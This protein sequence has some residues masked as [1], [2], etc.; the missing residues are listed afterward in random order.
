MMVWPSGSCVPT[1]GELGYPAIERVG[2]WT[3]FVPARTPAEIV[4][5]LNVAVR[6]AVRVSEVKAG[7]TNLSAEIGTMPRAEFAQLVKA[8]YDR[9]ATIVQASGFT[10]QD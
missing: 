8:E 1:I 2:W 3:V 9:W 4:D 6:D 10:P 7:L 5:R